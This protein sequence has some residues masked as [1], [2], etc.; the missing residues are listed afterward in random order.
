MLPFAF[1]LSLAQFITLQHTADLGSIPPYEV[2]QLREGRLVVNAK[3]IVYKMPSG[4]QVTHCRHILALFLL[5]LRPVSR[6][7]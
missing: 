4:A 3:P 1:D 6:Y 7:E 5:C 2:G